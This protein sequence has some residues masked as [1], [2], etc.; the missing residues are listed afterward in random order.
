MTIE[1]IEGKRG[2][3]LEVHDIKI[4]IE[5][6]CRQKEI[7]KI[8]GKLKCW[9]M[10]ELQTTPTTGLCDKGRSVL[11]LSFR[12]R[13]CCKMLQQQKNRQ[14]LAENGLE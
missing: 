6:N 14:L 10:A 2:T 4:V 3:N 11:T 9:H 12:C 5:S 7:K 1:C 13:C 8:S